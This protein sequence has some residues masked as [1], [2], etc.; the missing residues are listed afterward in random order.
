MSDATALATLRREV[1]ERRK[2]YL[3]AVTAATGA[4]GYQKQHDLENGTT[5]AL[6]SLGDQWLAVQR[7]KL[8]YEEAMEQLEAFR[9][10]LREEGNDLARADAERHAR[11]RERHADE[12]QARA[13]DMQRSM[14]HSQW[15]IALFTAILTVAT[16]LGQCTPKQ[17]DPAMG[18]DLT[19]LE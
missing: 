15:V 17:H 9:D 7:A 14:T 10:L 1:E 8:A 2:E 5:S 16:V 4:P 13:D 18:T 12:A 3:A 11:D 6:T 19:S